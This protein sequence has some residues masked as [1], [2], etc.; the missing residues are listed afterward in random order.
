MKLE[1]IGFYTLS[2]K[3]AQEVSWESPLKRCELIL[4]HRCNFKCQYCRGIKDELKGDM[5]YEQAKNVVDMWD[6]GG[7][8]NIRFSG[9][10]PTL[11]PRLEELVRFTKNKTSINRIALSTNG[12]A[13]IKT[14][15]K[16]FYSGVNDF[17]ISLDA[18]CSST[19]DQMA[20][21]NGKFKHI[22]DVITYLSKKTYV[23]VGIVLDNRNNKELLE[24]VSHATGL[25]VSDIR[26]IPSAQS[27]HRLDIDVDTDLK[28]LR[29][30]INNI[31]KGNHVRGLKNSDC[32]KC[33]L[34]KDDMV[35]L[36]DY[37]FPCVIYMREQGQPIGSVSGKSIQKIRAER[38]EWFDKADTKKDQICLK[39]CLDVCIDHNN[40]VDRYQK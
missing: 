37:H 23:T 38:K 32:G 20:G 13:S 22:C 8:E 34:V 28:I 33:H 29:Y 35:I 27:N 24:I 21:V 3:R 14:Y 18:C 30:R 5:P 40:T 12:S 25:G 2:D 10:E 19:A 15:E 7:L 26:I 39:N 9:G 36:S 4:T 1:D 17:S 16:L 11:W 31:K 6:S